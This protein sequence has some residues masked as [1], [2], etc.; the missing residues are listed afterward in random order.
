MSDQLRTLA[1][2]GGLSPQRDRRIDQVIEAVGN[3]LLPLVLGVSPAAYADL[4]S[5][6][7]HDAHEDRG[8]HP[9]RVHSNGP[10]PQ[11]ERLHHAMSLVSAIV[12]RLWATGTVRP[13]GGDDGIVEKAQAFM[14]KELS[15]PAAAE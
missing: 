3:W 15:A 1:Q 5:V 13:R 7:G 14:A 11:D 10:P 6:I 8:G 4:R 9:S 2:G 12:F